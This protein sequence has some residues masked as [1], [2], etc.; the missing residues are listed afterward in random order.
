MAIVPYLRLARPANLLT[1]VSDIWAGAA[2][3]GVLSTALYDPALTRS[4]AWLSLATIFL[5]AGGVVMNDVCD[6]RLDAVERPERPIPSGQVSLKAA[7]LWGGSLLVAGIL[8]ASMTGAVSGLLALGV[9]LTALLYDRWGKHHALLG[10]VNMGLCRGINLLLGMS[11]TTGA[12]AHM[13][14]AAIVPVIYIGAITLISRG[15]VHGANRSSLGAAFV[16]Y[17]VVILIIGW[18]AF[19]SDRLWE[20]LPFLVLFLIMVL[21]SL[22]KAFKSPTG[23]LIGKAVKAGVLSLI[24]LN[25]SWVAAGAGLPW[26]VATALLLPVSLWIARSFQVT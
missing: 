7:T 14:W 6:A 10:P 22:I 8:A 15:E 16:F 24:L 21:P 26:A 13:G 25:A 20:A 5:Y 11:I 3:S 1:S 19:L 4:L 2:L 17:A 23:P 12:I 9:A 18:E